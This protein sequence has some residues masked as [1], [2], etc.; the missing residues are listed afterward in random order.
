V[1]LAQRNDVER[2]LGV[3]AVAVADHGL[4]ET[5]ELRRRQRAEAL[6]EG[7]EIVAQPD[8]VLGVAL[9]GAGHVV[10]SFEVQDEL[11]DLRHH[12]TTAPR[13]H[14]AAVVE[15]RPTDLAGGHDDVLEV[16]DVPDIDNMPTSISK[17]CRSAACC[18]VS[19]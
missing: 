16:H 1:F 6:A 5:V 8:D 15:G 17:E 14:G 2:H 12:G 13:H 7:A 11:A 3:Q 19:E 4:D 9:D 10:A 18:W